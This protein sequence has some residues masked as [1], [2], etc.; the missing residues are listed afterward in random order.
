[1]TPDSFVR[2]LMDSVPEAVPVVEDHV[3]SN[4]SVLIHLL[5]ADLLRLAAEAFQSGSPE[6]SNGVL[7]V[8]DLALLSG[9]D[10]LSNAV[11]VSFIEHVGAFPDESPEFISSWP[12]GLL[13]ERERQL[14]WGAID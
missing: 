10:I 8:V 3:R 7:G 5:M 9:D 12:P 11:A 1:M 14:A 2:L 6:V 4:D 13:E